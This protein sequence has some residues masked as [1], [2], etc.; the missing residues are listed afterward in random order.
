[1]ICV[2]GLSRQGCDFDVLAQALTLRARVMAVDV[3]GRGHS[4][5]LADPSGYQVPTYAADLACN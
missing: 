1:M 4:D 3:A 2:H 5:W